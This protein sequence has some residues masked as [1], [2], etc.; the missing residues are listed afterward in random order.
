MPA[1]NAGEQAAEEIA[2]EEAD[3]SEPAGYS[4]VAFGGKGAETEGREDKKVGDEG[5]ASSDKDVDSG[6]DDGA[7]AG[8]HF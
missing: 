6:F 1:T 5:D 2:S 4:E 8:L 3:Y 7:K